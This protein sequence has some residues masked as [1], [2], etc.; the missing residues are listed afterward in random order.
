MQRDIH[1]AQNG[2]PPRNGIPH[3]GMLIIFALKFLLAIGIW[4]CQVVVTVMLNMEHGAIVFG[5]ANAITNLLLIGI[6]YLLCRIERGNSVV[7]DE[8]PDVMTE[9]PP[10]AAP[11]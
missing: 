7:V 3:H 4:V 2:L 6:V 9:P 11:N 1:A 8:I 10:P 5:F